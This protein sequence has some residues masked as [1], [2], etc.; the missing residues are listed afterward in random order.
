MKPI[1]L[2]LVLAA[3][4]L[5]GVYAVAN[6]A[7]NLR[8]EYLVNP[9]GID[10]PSPRLSWIITSN[11]RGEMQTAY[12][13]LV[14]SSSKLLNEDKGDLWDSGKVLSDES[15]QIAYAGSPLVSR[16]DCFWKVRTWNGDGKPGDWSQAA[17]W[18][19]GLLQPADWSAKWISP[20]SPVINTNELLVIRRATYEA[21]AEGR[22]ADVT[23]A[24]NNHIERG[25]LKIVVNN[26]TLG[27]DPAYN[28]VK[29]LRVEYEYGG[30]VFKKE[31]DENQT[32]TLPGVPPSV[33][34]LRKSF[35]L[36]STV[37]RAVLHVTALG[38]Y[39]V[40]INGHRVGDHV[41]APDWTDYR[42]RVRYQ[43]F[44]VTGL[45]KTGSNAI[46]AMLANGWFSG[47]IGN[48][49]Y[50]FFG[51]EPAFLSQLELT[52]ADGRTERIVTDDSW[53][54][55]DSPI[56]SSDFMLGEDYDSRL[57]IAGWDEAGLDESDWMPV[58]VR[59]ESFR[60]LDSQVM[61]PVREIC[62]LKPK[63]IKEPK[64]GSFV[65]DLGQNMV[66][67]VR[68]KV[69]APAGTTITLRHAEMLNPDGTLYTKNFARCADP[70][71]IM[72]AGAAASK[73][74]SHDLPF[75]VSVMWKSRA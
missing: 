50:E 35:E 46:A 74:G 30:Q 40:H 13:I 67:V 48:G 32:L 64:P 54:S 61:Q 42:K 19:M 20:A 45:I 62:E 49:G 11:R 3:L 58:T 38:L 2:V 1:K 37:Q 17:Q 15:S 31:V 33:P 10:A 12:Q 22:V 28:V 9:L 36:D 73:S 39:E 47:H 69:S 59:N 8:C 41:L 24:L 44:D 5:P 71:I 26:K 66:G 7:E 25:R 27:V 43:T 63:T 65:Y 68:L 16:E 75:T 56:Q 29:R 34:Y 23:A 70:P 60:E 21:V 52:Y 6:S 72:F 4:L 18:G 51:K 57:E 55:H 14:A 53:K